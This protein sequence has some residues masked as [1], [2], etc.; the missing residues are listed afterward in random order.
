VWAAIRNLL[1]DSSDNNVFDPPTETTNQP[2]ALDDPSPIHLPHG[3][4]NH[5]HRRVARI[6]GCNW[7]LYPGVGPILLSASGNISARKF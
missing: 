3:L 5:H 4:E 2:V 7:S 1:V 6:V